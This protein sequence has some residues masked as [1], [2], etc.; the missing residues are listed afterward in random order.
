MAESQSMTSA[1]VV[2]KALIEEHSDFLKESVAMIATEIMEAEITRQI[3]A[4]RGEVSEGRSTPATATDPGP[5]RPGSGRSSWRCPASA[6]D[7]GG[8]GIVSLTLKID[9]QVVGNSAATCPAGGCEKT[10][11]GTLNMVT[12]KGGSH[13][14]E[15]IAT[16]GAGLTT[17][18]AWTINVDP[19][20]SVTV[21]EAEDTLEAAE[22]TT[23]EPILSPEPEE[24]LP[25]EP[26][27][28]NEPELISNGNTINSVGAAT[29]LTMTSSPS[30][31]FIVETREG[32]TTVEP[33]Q[34]SSGATSLIVPGG[35]A[36]AAVSGNTGV[37][38]DSAVLPMNDGARTFQTIRDSLAPE[39]Y[40]W[41]IKLEPDQTLTQLD[42]QHAEV[43]TE[44]THPSFGIS[45]TPAHDAIGTEVPTKLAVTG[46]NTVTLTVSYKA[47][48][49]AAGGT[50]F[51]YPIV[52]GAGWQGGFTTYTVQ[53]PPPEPIEGAPEEEGEEGGTYGELW[54][55]PP[56][57]A[58]PAEASLSSGEITPF[59]LQTL[60][61]RQFRFIECHPIE[62]VIVDPTIPV[63]R[64]GINKRC[65]NPFA[66]EEGPSNIAFNFAIRGDF[67]RSP[68][69]FT[70]HLGGPNDHIECDKMYDSKN[71]THEYAEWEY[72]INP[73]ARC[74]WWGH[75]QYSEPV[76]ATLGHH[77]T[78]YGEWE[79]GQG[80]STSGGWYHHTAGLA[81]YIWG[82]SKDKYIG[83][84]VTTCIDC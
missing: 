72:Y 31:G 16:D 69:V 39:Q 24:S 56:V 67:Y 57:H 25:L 41:K 21:A 29:E 48:N 55:G 1:G 32:P 68:G 82:A 71:F 78:P 83:H 12:Y 66:N 40:S 49:P 73:T 11:S 65:G 74:V 46:P 36:P 42:S 5:G 9:G 80:P 70:K 4:G 64:P 15:L 75:T 33:L 2:A 13:P 8:R 6:K 38:S 18:K 22:V 34:T 47:G 50:P 14:A 7:P 77:I 51:V 17:K 62:A 20:G 60:E 63:I 54:V 58:T 84:H 52:A 28:P 81:L 27:D 23:G 43:Y 10:L 19:K 37:A 59:V 61:H 26:N 76:K 53:M 79:W 3:G 45:A 44:G 35:T 30:A